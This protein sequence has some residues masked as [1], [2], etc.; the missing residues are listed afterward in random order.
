[1]AD[2]N[3]R[4]RQPRG[5]RP[6][7]SIKEQQEKQLSERKQ[8]VNV[9]S[10]KWNRIDKKLTKNSI[11]KVKTLDEIRHENPR[12]YENMV[13]LLENQERY[14]KHLKEADNV[15]SNY[16]GLTPEHLV[17]VFRYAYA[18]SIGDEI[19]VNFPMSHYRDSMY[20]IEPVA[21]S[22]ARGSST[23]TS[24]YENYGDYGYPK[25]VSRQKVATGTGS[26]ANFTATITVK[27]LKAGYLTLVAGNA[28]VGWQRIGIDDGNGLFTSVGSNYPLS[29]ATDSTIDYTSG[30]LDITFNA[31]LTSGIEVYLEY[32][33]DNEI[34]TLYTQQGGLKLQVGRIDFQ[35][36][37]QTLG[38]TWS[39][40]SEYAFGTSYGEDQRELL[41]QSAIDYF[42]KASDDEKIVRLARIARNQTNT[43]LTFDTSWKASSA[44]SEKAYAQSLMRVFSKA[45]Q[46][47]QSTYNR[48]KVTKLICAN[49]AADYISDMLDGFT[50]EPGNEKA[51]GAYKMG[52]LKGMDVYRTNDTGTAIGNGLESGEIIAEYID[53]NTN[54]DTPLIYGTY[55]GIM[56]TPTNTFKNFDSEK[57]LGQMTDAKEHKPGFARMITLENL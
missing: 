53:F 44:S 21:S 42:R 29:T 2:L 51:Q 32:P 57:G 16:A 31:N 20:F 48:G 27:P 24:I 39:A 41:V 46:L 37:F 56:E 33:Y 22:S 11:R 5:N 34:S 54:G 47:M 23:T 35:P 8:Y 40:L 50:P 14:A 9:L 19:V 3:K 15:S 17:K 45:G 25:E 28:T 43:N 6:A 26:D 55:G 10:E 7:M 30:A 49:D 1:M 4:I 18:D 13:I 36:R 38:L 12:K 52:T